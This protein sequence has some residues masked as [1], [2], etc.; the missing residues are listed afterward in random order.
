MKRAPACIALLFAAHA[1]LAWAHAETLAAGGFLVG[2]RHP[3]TGPDHLLAMLAVGLWGAQL[4][5]P[6]VWMLPVT[7]PMIMAFAALSA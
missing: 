2:F 3:L 5:A 1:G 6:A 7:F 4:G